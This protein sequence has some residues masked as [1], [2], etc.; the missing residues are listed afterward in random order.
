MEA[1]KP[2]KPI[3]LATSDTID[4]ELAKSWW[5]DR[6]TVLRAL[7]DEKQEN[8]RR[9]DARYTM[10]AAAII[11]VVFGGM[12]SLVIPDVAFASSAVR[13]GAG[14]SA[15][16]VIEL[17]YRRASARSIDISANVV[18]VFCYVAWLVTAL[19]SRDHEA[20]S[21]YLIFG[22]IFMMV[23]NLIFNFRFLL[24]AIS[25]T[26]ILAVGVT[27]TFYAPG[28]GS[29]YA[30][31]FAVFYIA[32]FTATLYVN[33][34]LNR[35]RYNVFLNEL[36]AQLRQEKVT[37]RGETLLRL[38]HTDSLTGLKNRRAIDEELRLLWDGW[39]QHGRN[40]A[41]LL[42]DID[43]F[44]PFNDH[45]GHQEGD[46]CLTQV[47]TALSDFVATRGG[48]VGRYGGE[49]FIALARISRDEEMGA[50]AEALRRSIEG[51]RFPHEHRAD[52]ERVV[53][54]SIG[55]ASAKHL[56]VERVERLVS[57]ADRALYRA[58]ANGRNR[59]WVFDP[60]ADGVRDEGEEVALALPTAI[61]DGLVSL[62]YQPIFEPG[63][64]KIAAAE[65]LMRL[66]MPDGKPVSP[67]KFI[68]I[69]ERTGAILALGRWAIRT[70]CHDLLAPDLVP[71][72]SVN[73]SPLQLRA[74]GFAISVAAI[75]AEAGVAASRLAFEITE[76]REIET[77]PDVLRCI[78]EL[79]Q[80]GVKIWLDDFG[81]GFAGLSCLRAIDFD[82][83]KIDRSFLHEIETEQGAAMLTDILQLVLH[84]GPTVVVEGVE[85]EKQLR[86]LAA[87]GVEL[88]Q[89]YHLG[90]PS[91]VE[92]FHLHLIDDS[93]RLQQRA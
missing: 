58:K 74:P 28:V 37:E 67:L 80:L 76:G 30:L 52:R 57:A 81:T 70:A 90:R 50:L 59:V 44:K 45:Y 26:V 63:T 69:A 38:S 82:V 92:N 71:L 8:D 39:H 21:L 41:A 31:V 9:S 14:L 24:S 86:F 15:I 40:F 22:T 19:T 49:E 43:F 91:P 17:M 53:T 88:A 34:K 32:C 51:L 83:V 42:I 55:V 68:P 47:A 18:I 25:S 2:D 60:S 78:G 1:L 62:V 33:F 36:Q 12:D 85:T 75:V 72:V 89:G 13:F 87:S 20:L 54:V 77:H 61:E 73:V 7:Y 6:S 66:V 56:G 4:L 64:R 5:V 27:A 16:L 65:T 84:R 10:W 46:R 93:P 11:Y 79:R 3:M 35:E 23:S 29:A 48:V